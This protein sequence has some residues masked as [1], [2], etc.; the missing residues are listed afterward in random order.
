MPMNIDA[1]TSDAAMP[2]KP[3]KPL[4]EPGAGVSGWNEVP[5]WDAMDVENLGPSFR[6]MAQVTVM[7]DSAI[8]VGRAVIVRTRMDTNAYT[9]LL[10]ELRN[11]AGNLL[12]NVKAKT[13]DWLDATRGSVHRSL[14]HPIAGAIRFSRSTNASCLA[15]NQ[16]AY[17]LACIHM[18]NAKPEIDQTASIQIE[19]ESS[20][21]VGYVEPA[22][23]MV[24]G[25]FTAPNR[26]TFV[27]T[28]TAEAPIG[29]INV[30]DAL[31]LDSAGLPVGVEYGRSGF[32]IQHFGPVPPGG[33]A[34]Y[35]ASRF[36]VAGTPAKLLLL[37]AP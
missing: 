8:G 2:S 37:V 29:E 4:L 19:F 30:V 9:C 34:E 26:V 27:N 18:P 12:C 7:G 1:G 15:A 31:L 23:R 14:D 3:S 32:G 17:L 25:K 10:A 22:F 24:P 6:K 13:V 21:A 5:G 20:A 16:P 33:E 28:G 35:V 36:V 11:T